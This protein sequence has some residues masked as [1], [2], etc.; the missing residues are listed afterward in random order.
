MQTKEDILKEIN[1]LQKQLQEIECNN[2]IDKKLAYFKDKNLINKIYQ[3]KQKIKEYNLST[4]IVIDESNLKITILRNYNGETSSLH[5]KIEIPIHNEQTSNQALTILDNEISYC[6]IVYQLKNLLSLDEIQ[7]LKY[8]LITKN[9][10][11]FK[12][13]GYE[14]ELNLYNDGSIHTLKGIYSYNAVNDFITFKKYGF[15]LTIEN[16]KEPWYEHTNLKL[17]FDAYR[18]DLPFNKLY[19]TILEICEILDNVPD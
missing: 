16:D 12:Y 10:F 13:H 8:N 1:K 5:T 3:L 9:D 15:N 7:T 2:E 18:E 6:E 4:E 19:V 17:S 11:K 14:F